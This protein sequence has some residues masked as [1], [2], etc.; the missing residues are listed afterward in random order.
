MPDCPYGSE[1]KPGK[2]NYPVVVRYANIAIP[3]SPQQ[4]LW[5]L[6]KHAL[7]GGTNG[8]EVDSDLTNA[9]AFGGDGY[10]I[11]FDDIG[12][13]FCSASPPKSF[14]AATGPYAYL[15]PFLEN[16]T[17]EIWN[18]I[19]QCRLPDTLV[20]CGT[21]GGKGQC[22]TRYRVDYTF[23]YKSRDRPNIYSF[24]SYAYRWGRLKE[25]FFRE[26]EDQLDF[27][28][29]AGTEQNPDEREDTPSVSITGFSSNHFEIVNYQI[30]NISRLDRGLDNCC[31]GAQPPP[32]NY[33]VTDGQNDWTFRADEGDGVTIIFLP[34]QYLPGAPGPKGDKGDQGDPGATGAIGAKG[35]QGD[36]GLKGDKGDPGDP[37]APGAVGAP[38]APG[39]P[40]AKGDKGDKGAKGDPSTIL[41]ELVIL[42]SDSTENSSFTVLNVDPSTVK[43]VLKIKMSD[44]NLVK[45]I[46]EILGGDTWTFDSNDQPTVDI[47]ALTQRLALDTTASSK[48][49]IGFFLEWDEIIFKK[50]L[51]TNMNFSIR[52]TGQTCNSKYYSSTGK[53]LPGLHEM[54]YQIAGMLADEKQASCNKHKTLSRVYSILGGDTWFDNLE[55]TTPKINFSPEE[56]TEAT[57][58]AIYPQPAPGKIDALNLLDYLKALEAVSRHRSGF[59]RFPATVPKSLAG[60]DPG[61]KPY[62]MQHLGRSGWSNKSMD[63][64]ELIQSRSTT[65]GLTVRVKN[66]NL[67]IKRNC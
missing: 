13:T 38:G 67:R 29:V 41:A 57:R 24:T 35:D 33:P 60:E 7:V 27:V 8:I 5:G 43:L 61:R 17:N 12:S 54:L 23:Q 4:A 32:P 47:A 21:Y 34:G 28:I 16:R 31:E 59:H 62:R 51:D 19:C 58:A 26:A 6:V 52:S 9:L 48:S 66:L 22:P 39:S 25:V 40:G 2:G 42:P 65:E 64:M 37:G 45:R 1:A 53:G 10:G 49:L 11:L 15:Q 20:H 14:P 46:Y 3:T 30:T 50:Y 36:Q 18:E 56:A 63:C 44:S 55:D